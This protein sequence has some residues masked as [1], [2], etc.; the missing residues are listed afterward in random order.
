MSDLYKEIHFNLVNGNNDLFDGNGDRLCQILGCHE[1]NN[2]CSVN[3]SMICE[4]H[5]IM[6]H[7]TNLVHKNAAMNWGIHNDYNPFK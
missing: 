7:Y 5:Q 6:N 3:E 1:K 2:L 4:N